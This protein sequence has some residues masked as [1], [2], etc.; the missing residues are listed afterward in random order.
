MKINA[1]PFYTSLFSIVILSQL[2]LASFKG[3]VF[4][5]IF[6]LGIYFFF[7]KPIIYKGFLRIIT[8]VLL[9]FCIGFIGL[10]LNRY[11][12]FNVLKDIFHFI[13]PIT[14]LLIGYFLYRKINNFKVFVKTIVILGLISAVIHFGILFFVSGFSSVNKIREFGR[15]N[16]LELFS[17]FFLVFYK[18]FNRQSLFQKKSTHYVFVAFLLVSNILYFSRTMIVTA[19]IL[20]ASIYG[21]TTITKKGLKIIS[22]VVVFFIL[23]YSY[24]FS[25]KIDR[26]QPGL[27]S[28]LFKIKNAPSEIFKTKID[29]ENHKDLWDHWRAYEA[30]RA[31]DL[32]LDDPKSFLIGAGHGSLVNLKFFAPL[33]ENDK[34]K[35]IKYISELH[36]G[37]VYILYKTGLLGLVLYL[38]FAINL[39]TKIYAFREIIP[40]FISAIGLVFLFTTLTI[41]GIYNSRDIIVI[42]L[43]ALLFFEKKLV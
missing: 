4:L 36:N 3:N 14:G 12:L 40:C 8:P 23:L 29:R 25:V 41:T 31:F 26:N 17:L 2:Y 16:F 22:G 32:M 18:N 7:E 15:D 5:Q 37:Y 20:L 38:V 43:G 42:I 27:E 35:G 34:D 11:S 39:Y 9:L 30:K 21:Y 6:I 1:I 19:L 24:L 10:L 13:K 33:T 28:L